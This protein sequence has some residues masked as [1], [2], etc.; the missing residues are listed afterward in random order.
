MLD[1]DSNQIY[2][3]FYRER[4]SLW[5]ASVKGKGLDTMEKVHTKGE[6]G[7]LG[8][9]GVGMVRGGGGVKGEVN[10]V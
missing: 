7:E 5:S 8:G 1:S 2:T 10:I 3:G 6:A 4:R 9:E